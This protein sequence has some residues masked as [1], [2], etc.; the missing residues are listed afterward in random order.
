[1]TQEEAAAK[2]GE[3][4]SRLAPGV[5]SS[6]IPSK[7]ASDYYSDP[8][9][10]SFGYDFVVQGY[11][12]PESGAHLRFAGDTGELQNWHID[13]PQ[14]KMLLPPKLMAEAEAMTA[15]GKLP[16]SLAY[17]PIYW[18]DG[19]PGAARGCRPQAPPS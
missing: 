13:R 15:F 11:P 8:N 12:V 16:L 19:Y 4:L 7:N 18:S 17:T 3:W 5:K 10:F 14:G 2:A 9:S 1:M 6:L